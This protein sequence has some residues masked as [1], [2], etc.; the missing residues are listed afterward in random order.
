MTYKILILIT[1]MLNFV[2]QPSVGW[3]TPDREAESVIVNTTQA[4]YKA[5]QEQCNKI[6][7][8]PRQLHRLVEEIIIPITDFERM[9][10]WVL[11]KNWRTADSAQR[12]AFISEFRLLLVRTYATAIQMASLESIRYLP[13]RNGVKQ[14]TMIVKTEIRRP[15]EPMVAINYYLY[16]RQEQWL[17]YDIQVEGISLTT[18]YRSTFSEEIRKGGFSGLIKVMVNKNEK[19]VTRT[20]TDLIRKRVARVCK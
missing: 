8:D 18:N 7:Q 16:N 6:E 5:I 12:A 3:T 19:P 20:N 17:V 11:G 2:I 9:S 13:T 14:A 10:Q 1:V 15:G 4:I